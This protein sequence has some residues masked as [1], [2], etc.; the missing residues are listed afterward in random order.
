MPPGLLCV[1]T[2]PWALLA[3][4]PTLLRGYF[5]SIEGM[6]EAQ[7]DHVTVPKSHSKKVLESGGALL[8]L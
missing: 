7:G 1:W 6:T 4:I 8:P 5:H 3:Y 2:L